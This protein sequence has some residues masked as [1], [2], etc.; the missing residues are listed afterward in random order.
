[1]TMLIIN[2]KN[3]QDEGSTAIKKNIFRQ[4]PPA[5]DAATSGC[6]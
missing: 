3:V 4:K 5:S 1:M 6:C 2:L